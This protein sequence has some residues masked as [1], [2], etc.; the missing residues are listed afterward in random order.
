M[1]VKG[2]IR[3]VNSSIERFSKRD[4]IPFTDR[5]T[6]GL[7]KAKL[8]A[9]FEEPDA[10]RVQDRRNSAWER[11]RTYDDG[12]A[13]WGLL[14]P[15]WAR[16]RLLISQLLSD[17]RMGELR[18][19]NGSSF[20]PLGN[21]LS[22]ACKLTV[23]WTITL[24]A[25]GLFAKYSYWHRALKHAC[26][27]RFQDYCR[28]HR[29]NQRDIE[30]KLWKRF[31]NQKEPA[32]QIYCFKL[33]CV[34]TYVR[35]N[36]F[37]T[38][39][40]NNSKDRAICLEPLCNMLVQRAIGLGIRGCL[41][42]NLGIDLDT[43]ADVHRDR[44]RDPQVATIDLSDCSDA[45][46][47]RL[48]TYLL[49]F[50]VLSKVLAARSDMTLGP[51]DNFYIINKVSSMGNGFTFDLMTLILTALTRSFDP[52]ATVFGDDIICQNAVADDVVSNLQIADFRVN[53]D[54]TLIRS[55]YRESCGA[56][57]VDGYGYVTTFDQRWLKVPHDLIVTCNK[58]AILAAVHG[59]PFE[60]LRAEIWSH[61]PRTLLGAT[62]AR[63]TVYAGRPPAYELDTYIRYGPTFNVD[64]PGRM[65]RSLRRRLRELHKPGN[66]SVATAYVTSQVRPSTSL[67]SKDWDIFFQY[68]QSSRATRKYPRL[69][70]KSTLVVRVGEE[71]LGFAKALLP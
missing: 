35:G 50:R 39:P 56:H 28:R 27:K 31:K 5:A 63:P 61:V 48:I 55:P 3:A 65:L 36:R 34:V 32:F 17:F 4:N 45:I 23:N 52:A 68:L 11:W 25:F 12:L 64:P 10:S 70:L 66:I 42:R 71:Q 14:G 18:F 41:Q 69:V 51:D 43:L 8:I 40:K 57:F 9:K 13:K 67:R 58:V 24:D 20:E 62:V 26:K 30:R 6:K 19:T 37:S 59:E 29:L 54:K 21:Q 33:D 38:V 49:P 22:I 60:S 46:S 44:I 53:V 1:E 15:H 16:A 2:S 47:V 7:A